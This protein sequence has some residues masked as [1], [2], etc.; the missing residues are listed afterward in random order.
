MLE[1]P[2]KPRSSRTCIEKPQKNKFQTN[3]FAIISLIS[4]KVN[5]NNCLK[6]RC[7]VLYSIF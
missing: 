4:F 6:A 1:S 2:T 3:I 5:Y 7:F